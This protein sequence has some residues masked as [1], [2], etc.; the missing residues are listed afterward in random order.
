LKFLEKARKFF[1]KLVLGKLLAGRLLKLLQ[2]NLQLWQKMVQKK[3][4]DK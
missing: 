3:Q 2:L 4:Q 1:G